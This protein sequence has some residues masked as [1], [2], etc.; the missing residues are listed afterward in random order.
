MT[1]LLRV[2]I[3][4]DEAPAREG[5]RLRLRKEPDVTIIGEYADA[6]IALAEIRRDPPDVLFLDIEMPGLNGFAMLESATAVDLPAVVFVTA[7]DAHAVRAFDV[8]ALDYLLKPVEQ[9]RLREALSRAR[10]YWSDKRKAEIADRV[11]SIVG[12]PGNLPAPAPAIQSGVRIPIRRDGTIQFVNSPDID[13]IDAAGD[14]VRLHVGRTTH[15]LRKSMGE[16]LGMLDERQFVRIHRSTIVNIDRVKELQPWFHGEYVVVLHDG[17]RLKL[18]RGQKENLAALMG[19]S[20]KR[21][22]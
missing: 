22:R 19:G 7:H 2:M 6:A 15:S 5:L 17:T 4:D 21:S 16:M 9:E 11:K 20:G 14:S 8:R 18:S 12:D 1:D 13:W 3:V 10:E